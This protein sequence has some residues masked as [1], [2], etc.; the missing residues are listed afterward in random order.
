MIVLYIAL[1]FSLFIQLFY[2][3][4]FFRKV[5]YFK[6]STNSFSPNVS[7]IICAK[8]EAK[9]LRKN[10]PLILEQNYTNYE[11]IVV[12]DQSDDETKYILKE[13]KEIFSHLNIVTITENVYSREGKKFALTLGL[14]TAKFI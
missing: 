10:L 13:L 5:T 7:I 4:F 11:V 3:L 12:N 14:K 9:N 1:F 6:P 2:F 8:N